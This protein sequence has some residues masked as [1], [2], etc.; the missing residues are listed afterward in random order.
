QKI[1]IQVAQ[2]CVFCGQEEEIFE[3]LFFECSYTS[4]VWKRL[5]NW[6]GIQRQI[7]T[8]EEELQWVTYHARKKKGIGNIIVAVFGMLLHSLWRDRNSI[9]LQNGST[10]AEQICREITSYVHIK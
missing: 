1:G 10:S 8:W 4:D 9:R 2:V 3:H 7:Q 5:L 6:M